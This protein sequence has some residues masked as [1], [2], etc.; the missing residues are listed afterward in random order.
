[1]ASAMSCELVLLVPLYIKLNVTCPKANY[2]TEED[3]HC[4]QKYGNMLSTL[5]SL[6]SGFSFIINHLKV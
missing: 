1:M 3:I 4:M 5:V 2:P 6:L